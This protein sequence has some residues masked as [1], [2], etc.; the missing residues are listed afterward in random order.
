MLAQTTIFVC[1]LD[2]ICGRTFA[3]SGT[4]PA[5]NQPALSMVAFSSAHTSSPK[6]IVRLSAG[7]AGID[8]EQCW[9]PEAQQHAIAIKAGIY[10]PTA[11]I[12]QNLLQAP[13]CMLTASIAAA[14]FAPDS[15]SST[16]FSLPSQLPCT[17]PTTKPA[18]PSLSLSQQPQ[19]VFVSETILAPATCNPV[20]EQPWA[21]QSAE[22]IECAFLQH[23]FAQ[24]HLL[25]Q[26][27]M[28]QWS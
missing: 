1:G 12:S 9:Y 2:C 19:K 27:S 24:P 10:L 4:A 6:L 16:T 13:N 20:P 28:G 8:D 7:L 23:P 14:S 11:A 26:G 17:G 3:A 22:A 25:G 18:V 5:S 21:L 15:G